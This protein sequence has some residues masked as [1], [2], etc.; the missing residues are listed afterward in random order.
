MY[1]LPKT[2]RD[3]YIVHYIASRRHYYTPYVV[4]FDS[5]WTSIWD[6]AANVSRAAQFTLPPDL[7]ENTV[8]RLKDETKRAS[9]KFNSEAGVFYMPMIS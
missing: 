7:K 3:V 4:H 1:R 2:R 9:T 5:K 6:S 8:N